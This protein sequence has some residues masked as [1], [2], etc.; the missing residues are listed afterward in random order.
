MI[1]RREI[2][3][4]TVAVAATSTLSPVIA[5]A[6]IYPQGDLT[7][8]A[9]FREEIA[10]KLLY[11]F[12]QATSYLPIDGYQYDGSGN[13]SIASQFLSLFRG[14]P[15][16]VESLPDGRWLFYG[17]MPRNPS[18]IAF[19]L[20]SA[21]QSRIDGAMMSYKLCPEGGV[22][23]TDPSGIARRMPCE[24]DAGWGIFLSRYDAKSDAMIQELTATAKQYTLGLNRMAIKNG[25]RT[26]DS[27]QAKTQLIEVP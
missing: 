15:G 21:S 4:A 16:P 7:W 8:V 3:G 1:T 17:A 10:Q 2:L 23:Y 5:Q 9:S 11:F 14:A 26:A 25:I 19:V 20:M 18:F 13:H 22:R 6:K 24:E 27:V 12:G